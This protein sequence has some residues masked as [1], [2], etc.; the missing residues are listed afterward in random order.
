M[1]PAAF[2]SDFTAPALEAFDGTAPDC[3]GVEDRDLGYC[4]DDET[5]YLDETDLAPPAYEEIGDFALATAMSLPYSLA[6]RDQ[7]GLST[8]DGAATRSAVCLTGWYEAQWFNGAFADTTAPSSAPA[9]STRPCS[10]CSPTA[11]TRGLPEHVGLGLRAGRRVPPRLPPG[12]RR[13]RPRALTDQ[14]SASVS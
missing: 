7:A 2:D 3:A 6:V 12:R 14:N 9:T 10:S 5:V 4:A 11:S 13:L 1:F 8:D